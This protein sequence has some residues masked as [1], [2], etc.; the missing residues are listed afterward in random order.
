MKCS[1]C[2]DPE[3]VQFIL[4]WSDGVF[5]RCKYHVVNIDGRKDLK[6]ITLEEAFI[7]SVQ[8]E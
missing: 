5:C 1:I 2:H 3:V 6:N 4:D 8:G 7:A